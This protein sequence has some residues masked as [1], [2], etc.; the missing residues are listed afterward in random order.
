MYPD[1]TICIEKETNEIAKVRFKTPQGHKIPAP[2]N[3]NLVNRDNQVVPGTPYGWRIV[4]SG[5]YSLRIG[6][7]PIFIINNQKQQAI[8]AY[9]DNW[10]VKSATGQ[11]K[12]R[13]GIKIN[14]GE[15]IQAL[16][17]TSEENISEEEEDEVESES[18]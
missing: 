11:V 13:N 7:E 6:D 16:A 2:A 4:W 5:S 14:N 1:Y 3:A 12:R 8:Q 10:I 9:C 15:M 18:E 17:I